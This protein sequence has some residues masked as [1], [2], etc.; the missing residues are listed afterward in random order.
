MMRIALFLA[1]NIAIMALIS[2]VFQLFGFQ[3]LLE[4]MALT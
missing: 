2:I 1:T 3:G 4:K